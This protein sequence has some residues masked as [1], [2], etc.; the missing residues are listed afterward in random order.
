VPGELL[1]D[2]QVYTGMH[3]RHQE[4]MTQR[5]KIGVSGWSYLGYFPRWLTPAYPPDGGLLQIVAPA[6][7]AAL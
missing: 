1:L 6:N 3:E 2:A 4:R 5:M 7:V